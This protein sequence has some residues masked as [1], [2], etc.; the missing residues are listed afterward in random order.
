[1]GELK[2]FEHLAQDA[3]ELDRD[4]LPLGRKPFWRF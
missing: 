1:M 2:T 4:G 3:L